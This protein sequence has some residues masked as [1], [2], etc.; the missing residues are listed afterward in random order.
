MSF[1]LKKNERLSSKRIIDSLFEKSK[2]INAYPL[3]FSYI[4]FNFSEDTPGQAMMI[5][6]KRRLKKAK[7]RNRTKRI[8]REAYRLHKHEI[9]DIDNRTFAM[10]ISFSGKEPLEL[11]AAIKSM[12]KIIDKL[13]AAEENNSDT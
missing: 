8:M 3:R 11:N 13:K 10:A 6:S 4:P 9:Y 1:T 5:V 2:F 12:R 7:D